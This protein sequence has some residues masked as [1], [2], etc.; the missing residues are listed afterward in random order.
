VGWLTNF[1]G[2]VDALGKQCYNNR[3]PINE[4]EEAGAAAHDNSICLANIYDE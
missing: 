3:T 4:Q 2:E 1:G